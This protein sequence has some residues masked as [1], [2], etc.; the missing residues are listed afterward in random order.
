MKKETKGGTYLFKI[1][2][3]D[4]DRKKVVYYIF[5]NRVPVPYLSLSMDLSLPEIVHA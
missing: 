2:S 5:C 1:D 3:I 4:F